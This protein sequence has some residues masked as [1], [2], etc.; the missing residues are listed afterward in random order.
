MRFAGCLKNGSC[1]TSH[2]LLFLIVLLRKPTKAK[3][4]LRRNES[5]EVSTVA[6][7]IL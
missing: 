1:S 5:A 4:I 7:T 3:N 2:D 6:A